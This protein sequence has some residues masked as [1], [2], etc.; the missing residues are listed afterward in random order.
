M[1]EAPAPSGTCWLAVDAAT[2]GA[3]LV[4]L[5]GVDGAL[6]AGGLI[7]GEEAALS[8]AVRDALAAA[9]AQLGGVVAGHG[10]GSY[11]GL[12]VG[13]A[14]ALGVAQG[15]GLPLWTVP[16]LQVTAWRLDPLADACVVVHAAGR[17]A[18][19]RQRFLARAGRWVPSAPA[20]WLPRGV[21]PG[22]GTAAWEP[23]VWEPETLGAAR[24]AV[25]DRLGA[26][27]RCALAAAGSAKPVAYHE[28]HAEYG[29][30]WT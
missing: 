10:P 28:V 6:R 30:P 19:F 20:L 2:R 29:I 25:R 1:A 14:A 18:H 11:T 7:T 13:L 8:R 27:A 23:V 15:R 5:V 12:R 24:G 3:V 9:G 17:S 21:D 16:S 26:L 22:E 4:A